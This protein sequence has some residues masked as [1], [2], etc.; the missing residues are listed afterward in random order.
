MVRRETI[1]FV[2]KNK[3]ILKIVEEH[4]S[5]ELRKIAAA[6][7]LAVEVEKRRGR[8]DKYENEC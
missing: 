7:R 6:L 4:G 3:D 8:V 2:E 5:A 1:E